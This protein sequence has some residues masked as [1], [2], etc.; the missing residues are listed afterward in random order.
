M[1]T[2]ELTKEMSTH[3]VS[4]LG[5]NYD[6]IQGEDGLWTIRD[7]PITGEL[8]KGVKGNTKSIDKEWLQKSAV[9]A[10]TR[11]KQDGFLPPLRID[12]DRFRTNPEYTGKFLLTRVGSLKYQGRE[13]PVV[14]A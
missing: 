11:F 1:A 3:S 10:Q 13:I 6:A 5:G 9:N 4:M 2:E 12:H 14:F 7:V 8:P